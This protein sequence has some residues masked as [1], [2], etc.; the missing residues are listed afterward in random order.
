MAI[1]VQPLSQVDK[2]KQ[3]ARDLECDDDDQR[4]RE[5]LK[6]VAKQKQM[7]TK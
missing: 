5:R 4:F 2:F 6:K 1:E 3:A 7:G